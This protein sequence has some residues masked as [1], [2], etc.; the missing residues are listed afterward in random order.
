MKKLFTTLAVAAAAV[1][2]LPQASE[3]RSHRSCEQSYTYVSGYMACGTPIYTKR[4]FCHYDRYGRPVYD[5]V[6]IP[7][8]HHYNRS[9][10]HGQSAKYARSYA[11]V[12]GGNRH[13]NRHRH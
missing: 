12:R 5:Y 7:S 8:K 10:Y 2:M 9:G 3:A 1:V 11:E 6:R 13:Q 4:V